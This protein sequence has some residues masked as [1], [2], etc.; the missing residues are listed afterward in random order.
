M[1]AV[2]SALQLRLWTNKA[3]H[4]M[5][6]SSLGRLVF[7]I[8]YCKWTILWYDHHASCTVIVKPPLPCD[9]KD[10]G[11]SVYIIVEWNSVIGSLVFVWRKLSIKTGTHKKGSAVFNK[12]YSAL[13]SIF[14]MVLNGL[15]LCKKRLHDCKLKWYQQC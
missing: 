2:L 12:H 13:G 15:Y 10:T 6:L 14:I 11:P 4:Y 5:Q 9:T 8:Y 3:G 7:M 1:N